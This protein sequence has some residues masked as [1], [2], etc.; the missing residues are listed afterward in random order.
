MGAVMVNKIIAYVIDSKIGKFIKATQEFL[1]GHKTNAVGFVTITQGVLGVWEDLA[2]L[3]DTASLIEFAKSVQENPDWKMI[4]AGLAL[5]TT[6][7]AIKKTEVAKKPEFD[8]MGGAT[9]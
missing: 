1:K 2:A 3:P 4:L 6:R 9:Q 5:M 8:S 7:A